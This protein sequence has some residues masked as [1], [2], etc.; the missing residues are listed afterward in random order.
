MT[1]HVRLFTRREAPLTPGALKLELGSE[2]TMR[3]LTIEGAEE[4]DHDWESLVIAPDPERP[5]CQLTKSERQSDLVAASE[6]EWFIAEAASA[7]PVSAARWVRSFLDKCQYIYCCR[8]FAAFFTEPYRLVPHR[9]LAGLREAARDGII[10]A[11]EE[12]FSNRQDMLITW[13]FPDEASGS[14][15]AAVLGRDGRWQ[16]FMMSLDDQVHRDAFQAG[17]VPP[18]APTIR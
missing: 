15:E 6:I 17:R 18:G 10:H 7:R 1:Y 9:L 5:I 8:C 14:C 3:A 11:E 12:G 16:K 13:E 4:T 2:P